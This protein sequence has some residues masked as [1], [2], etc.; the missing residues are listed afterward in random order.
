MKIVAEISFSVFFVAI[1]LATVASGTALRNP[2]RADLD[3]TGRAPQAPA[4]NGWIGQH[5]PWFTQSIPKE[6]AYTVPPK[7]A[8]PSPDPL[9]KA[10]GPDSPW[11]PAPK[12][13]PPL[14]PV[15]PSQGTD[16]PY[17]YRRDYRR[18][19]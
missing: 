9:P 5:W 7:P 1:L 11:I 19:E 3:S 6:P 16:K 4:G 10:E 12:D 8:F 15:Y 17:D 2:V 18:S 14:E 13:T